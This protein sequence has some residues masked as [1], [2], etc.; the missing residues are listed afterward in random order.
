MS[1]SV[2][3]RGDIT[4]LTPSGMF[5]GGEET[6]QLESRFQE[7]AANGTQKL[8]VNLGKTAFM[9]SLVVN[10]LVHAYRGYNERGARMKLCCVGSRI[11]QILVI[12]RLCLVFGDD[13]YETEE[14]AIASF[15][16]GEQESDAV[17]SP[18]STA[19]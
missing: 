5:W 10:E 15:A 4:I 6:E 2:E 7:L 13:Q 11:D 1:L 3:V 17:S 16:C 19:G 8:L 14:E 12:T 9:S 18:R